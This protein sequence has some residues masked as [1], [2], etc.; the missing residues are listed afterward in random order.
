MVVTEESN[1][2]FSFKD[3]WQ[4]QEQNTFCQLHKKAAETR[5]SWHIFPIYYCNV[6]VNLYGLILNIVLGKTPLVLLATCELQIIPKC[7]G[8]K[9][10]FIITHWS[11]LGRSADLG[12]AWLILAWLVHVFS[13]SWWDG[14]ELPG[15]GMSLLTWINS[16]LNGFSSSCWLA[17]I[18][19]SWWRQEFKV[20]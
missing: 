5:G 16:T 12:R 17:Q 18:F 14:W 3:F 13:V 1:Y 19:F 7:N 2:Y 15:L 4:K 10:P 6:W 9:Q 8:L 20:E 11:I